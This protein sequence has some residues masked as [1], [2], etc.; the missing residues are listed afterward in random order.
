L[1]EEDKEDLFVGEMSKPCG[2]MEKGIADEPS[3]QR[4]TAT[5]HKLTYQLGVGEEMTQTGALLYALL[6]ITGIWNA[7][8]KM[9]RQYSRLRENRDKFFR[10]EI[11]ATI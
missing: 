6:N 1:A 7:E 5:H 2:E 10:R 9:P 3:A 4:I 8:V 11:K